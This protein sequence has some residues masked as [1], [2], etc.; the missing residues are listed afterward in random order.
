MNIY[1]STKVLPY[2]YK[3]THKVT[4]QFYFGYRRANKVPSSED[5]GVVYFTSSTR[6]KNLGFE[7]FEYEIIA[8]FFDY[9]DALDFEDKII[10]E[11]WN[12]P[13]KLNRCVGGVKFHCT[14]HSEE[15][16]QLMSRRNKGQQ[17]WNKGIP[18]TDD[19]KKKLSEAWKTRPPMTDET[20]AKIGEAS[21]NCSDVTKAKLSAAF[22]GKPRSAEVIAKIK[23]TKNSAAGRAK[24]Q[25]ANDSRKL[26]H[27][28]H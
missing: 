22:K 12:N 28:Q 3:L 24:I 11:N 6:V 16:R 19:Q 7:N 27:T 9:H 18:L 20:R 8:E 23:A 13:L 26:A 14:G 4:G 5:L 17:A 21:R 15:T 1:P 10:R 2:V 25:A